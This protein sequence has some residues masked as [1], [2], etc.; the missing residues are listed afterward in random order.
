MFWA[1]GRIRESDRCARRVVGDIVTKT[2]PDGSMLA[3]VAG[4]HTLLRGVEAE[5]LVESSTDFSAVNQATAQPIYVA[6]YAE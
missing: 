1:L 6:G 3:M 2:L 5:I 4:T